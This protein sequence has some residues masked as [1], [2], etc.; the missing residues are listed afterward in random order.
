MANELTIVPLQ[1]PE[2][3]DAL[4]AADFHAL[5]ETLNRIKVGIWDNKDR[6]STPE[7]LLVSIQSDEYNTKHVFLAKV[8]GQIVGY[9]WSSWS[10]KDNPNVA[11]LYVAV[12]PEFRRRGYGKSMLEYIEQLTRS[13]GRTVF[14]VS[15]EHPADFD[16]DS[17]GNVLPK[18]GTG[19]LPADSPA[20]LF[21]RQAGYELEMIERFSELPLPLPAEKLAHF[22]ETAQAVSGDRYRLV[23]WQD[24]VPEEW[25]QSFTVA[26]TQMS[27]DIPMAGLEAEAE[28]W[29]VA[30]LRKDESDRL[31][32][33]KSNFGCLAVDNESAEIAAYTYIAYHPAKP[34]LLVQEDTL[35]SGAHRGKRLGM[36]IKAAN[37][38]RLAQILPQ[39][40]KVITWN[41]AQNDHMLAI[42]VN[43]G[44]VPVGYIGEWQK[45]SRETQES[46]AQ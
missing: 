38:Q 43:L 17:L 9:C 26:L 30:R 27:V 18:S 15:T 19:A 42:N 32:A 36:L 22:A 21:A 6:L 11:F 37:L 20:V 33:G 45:I 34:W 4:N 28:Y 10:L 5:S 41:A 16:L 3:G 1:P 25:V 35:V 39:V 14:Q 2:T 13:N 8:A 24:S 44:F 7:A 46:A 23:F 31:A 40:Q 12:L 29:D